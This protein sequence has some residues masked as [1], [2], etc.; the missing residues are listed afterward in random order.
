M[1]DRMR[2]F[3]RVAL[4]MLACGA[5][6]SAQTPPRAP[7][8]DIV[9]SGSLRTRLEAWDWFDGDANSDYTFSGSLVRLGVRQATKKVSWQLE[10][11]IPVLLGLPDDAVAAGAQGQLGFGATYYVANDNSRNAAALF[12]KQAFVRLN[13]LGGLAGQS[14]TLGR[15]DFVEGAEVAPKNATLAAVKRDRI[16]HRLI[17]NFVFTHVGRSF[18][19]AQYVVD[20]PA[21][22]VTA[23]AG[24]PTQGVFQAN[25]WREVDVNVGYGALTRQVASSR[26]AAEWRAFVIAYDDRRDAVVKTDN[27]PL[28]VR[29]ADTDTTTLATFGGHVLDTV[30]TAAGPIDVLLW[31]AL[32]T[33]SW[34]A[35]SHRAGAFAI[36]GGWQPSAPTRLRPWIRGGYDFGSGDRDP[37]DG[38]HGTFFQ[39]LPT[40]RVYA[41]L[42]FFNMMNMRDAFGELLLRP[43]PKI[44]VR[45]DGHA[46]DLAEP[47]DL[48]Y[49]GGGAFQPDTFG[50]TG[51]PS[52][53]HDGFARLVDGSVDITVNPR[54]NVTGYLGLA[55]GGPVIESIYPAGNTARFGYVELTVRF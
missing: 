6:A 46:L 50:F 21:W 10:A 37:T 36:E 42:P 1:R 25:G 16:A 17:G 11:G 22:N 45:V 47:N 51:R 19:G 55:R 53:G 44:T 54:A 9:V 2:H 38:R 40:P 18:D 24:R 32:Q 14:L 20:K 49:S 7:S 30:T 52:G 15:M 26:G 35:Q 13:D 41:R 28:A 31:A 8:S 34:G 48:W 27:R 12:L 5:P 3:A 29:R 23:L 33:G 39:V 4:L 43:T